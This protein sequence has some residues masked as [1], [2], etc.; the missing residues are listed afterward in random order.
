MQRMFGRDMGAPNVL[1]RAFHHQTSC[2]SFT[3][4]AAGT[5]QAAS[6]SNLYAMCADNRRAWAHMTFFTNATFLSLR[7]TKLNYLTMPQTSHQHMFG[8]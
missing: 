1:Q 2:V 8:I 5:V 4:C 3:L 6:A 7:T